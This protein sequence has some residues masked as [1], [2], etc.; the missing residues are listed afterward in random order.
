[1]IP[2]FI[3]R[4]DELGSQYRGYNKKEQLPKQHDLENTNP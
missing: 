3:S 1:M 2:L 4:K